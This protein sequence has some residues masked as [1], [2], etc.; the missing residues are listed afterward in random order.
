M[1]KV[2]SLILGIVMLM[3]FTTVSFAAETKNEAETG[4]ISQSDEI[5]ARLTRHKING[6]GTQTGGN[7]TYTSTITRT[8]SVIKASGVLAGSNTGGNL[9][10]VQVWS[11]GNILVA[12]G[13][14]R[15]DGG[16]Y[17][18]SKIIPGNYE[19]GTYTIKVQPSFVG[20]YDVSTSFYY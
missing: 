19:A 14:I 1:K 2:V 18:L 9:M 11:S 5:T 8:C 7:L 15:L 16:E 20:G 13:Q 10:T 6:V 12:G 4:L 3:S 17:T